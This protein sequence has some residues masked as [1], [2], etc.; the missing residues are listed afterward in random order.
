MPSPLPVDRLEYRRL[1]WRSRIGTA[2][3]A[4]PVVLGVVQVVTL[5]GSGDQRPAALVF[6]YLGLYTI[7]AVWAS[8]RLWRRSFAARPAVLAIDATP[9]EQVGVPDLDDLAPGRHRSLSGEQ[10]PP[11]R[12]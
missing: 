6:L 7:V 5:A 4:V 2:L 3:L 10:E 8:V 9:A 12:W 11:R 1:L